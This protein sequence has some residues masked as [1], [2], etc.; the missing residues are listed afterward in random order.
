[1]GLDP[2]PRW[3]RE[4]VQCGLCQTTL[5]ACGMCPEHIW[6]SV[7]GAQMGKFY[8]LFHADATIAVSH[9]GLIYMKVTSSVCRIIRSRVISSW[10]G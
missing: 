8:E 7:S 9:L 4:A 10:L 2:D 1:V 6:L 3:R 5:A